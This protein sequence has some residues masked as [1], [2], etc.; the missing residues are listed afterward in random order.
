MK[1]IT[2]LLILFTINIHAQEPIVTN[3]GDFHTVKTYNG[4]EVNLIKSSENKLEIQGKTAERISVKNSNGT[5]KIRLDL[6][7][8]YLKHK[9]NIDL[10]YANK[11]PIIDANEGSLVTSK[12][13][14]KQS[15]LEIKV[16]E[17]AR[18]NLELEVEFLEA[19]VITGGKILLKGTVVSQDVIA[20]TGGIYR[21]FNLQSN[22]TEVSASSGGEANVKAIKVLKARAN[23][24]GSIYYEGN[25][26]V[27]KRNRFLGG[28]VKQFEK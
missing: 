19:K 2:L 17:G 28:T 22:N 21:A 26:E 16:Q 27:L 20:R 6:P 9:V 15:Q 24:G 25:P 4:L 14:I 1:K 7:N 12:N 5:L 3:L 18:V 13:I 10:Y 8:I 23:L 11:V